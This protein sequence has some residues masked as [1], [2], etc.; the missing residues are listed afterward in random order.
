M[1]TSSSGLIIRDGLETDIESCLALDADYE[2][3]QVWQM[4]FQPETSGRGVVF[5]TERLPREMPVVYPLSEYRLRLALAHGL[6]FLV[7]ETRDEPE[8]LG[9]L[10]MQADPI[11]RSAVIQDIVVSRPLRRHGIGTRL[12]NV[13]RRWALERDLVQLMGVTQTKNYPAIAFFQKQGMGFCGYND[14]YFR[15]GDIAVFFGQPLR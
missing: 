8:M 13:A 9:Y 1:S 11:Q 12:Y 2:T 10:L 5:R 4:T 3:T 6:C 14:Q 15:S 7:A